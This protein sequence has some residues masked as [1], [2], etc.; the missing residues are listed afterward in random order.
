M[1][2]SCSVLGRAFSKGAAIRR[3][4]VRE[5]VCARTQEVQLCGGYREDGVVHAVLGWSME[6]LTV[7]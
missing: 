7:D 4:S 2:D 3:G 6:A 5:V 1:L